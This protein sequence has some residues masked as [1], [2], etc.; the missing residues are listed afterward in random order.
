MALLLVVLSHGLSRGARAQGPAA[1]PAPAVAEVAE[2][3]AL[4]LQGLKL[5][6][7]GKDAEALQLFV[8]AQELAP[9]PRALA[10]RALAEQALG[11]WAQAEAH[12]KEALAASDDAWIAR[13]RQ[14]LDGALAVIGEHLG[15]LQVNGGVAGAELRLD[16]QLVGTLPLTAPLRV[17]TGR[18]LLEVTLTG[19]YPVRREIAIKGG[20]LSTESIELV[21]AP[22]QQPDASRAAPATE[23]PAA[24]EAARAGAESEPSSLRSL[25]PLVFWTA[26]GVTAVLG[27]ITVWS[28]LNAS[29]KND[30]YEDYAREPNATSDQ[31][32]RGFDDAESAQTRTNVLLASTG[33]A[34]AA[35]IAIGVFFTDWDGSSAEQAP[36][37]VYSDGTGHGVILQR[38][39]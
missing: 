31:A 37:A 4:I 33:V 15:Y 27:G 26:A 35:T 24:S 12:L 9:T 19:Y 20:S 5:R 34:A 8:R 7:Q 10:Q 13:H 28:G 1:A 18:P 32:V 36:I 6:E 25:S 23:P 3:D 22:V 29:A 38:Q 11:D 30:A 16:G 14:A 17:V 39:F 2:S 21:P